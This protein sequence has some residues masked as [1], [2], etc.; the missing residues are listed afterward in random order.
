M[1][2]VSLDCPFLISPLVFSNVYL[3]CLSSSNRRWTYVLTQVNLCA[4]PGGY[5]CGSCYSSFWFS[6][7]C[8]F[9]CLRPVSCVPNVVSVSRLS[10]LD[11]PLCLPRWT[12]VLTQANLCAY[13]GEPMCLPRWTYVLTQVNICAYPGGYMCLPR[14]TYDSWFPPWFSLTFICCVC[15]HPASCVS[16]VVSVSRLSILDFPLGF[17]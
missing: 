17:L 5:M 4:Y 10:I 7:L 15:L 14:W 9:V 16:N 3:L 2:S 8:C 13:P 12:Y 1:L 6:V 11:F